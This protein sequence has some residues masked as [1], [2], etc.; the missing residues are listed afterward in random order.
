MNESGMLR[1]V[2]EKFPIDRQGL[3]YAQTFPG[4]VVDLIGNGIELLLG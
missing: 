2:Q 1:A 3:S 4:P